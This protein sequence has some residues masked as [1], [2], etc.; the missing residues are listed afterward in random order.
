MHGQGHGALRPLH[1]RAIFPRLHVV[2]PY[3]IRIGLIK[4][5][6]PLPYHMYVSN[7]GSQ[8][9][10]HFIMDETSGA[11]QAQPNVE[12]GGAPG[13]VTTDASQSV[14]YVCLSGR[15]ELVSCRID[16]STGALTEIG[17]TEMNE[18]PPHIALQ[19]PTRPLWVVDSLRRCRATPL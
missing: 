19:R 14:M 15:Q 16:R 4:G 8:F 7:S 1:R 2:L 10:S 18:C 13:A 11:L 6:F 12:L 9:L 5:E 3:V 17:A